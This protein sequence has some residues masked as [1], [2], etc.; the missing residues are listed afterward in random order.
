MKVLT[1]RMRGRRCCLR[2]AKISS[3]FSFVSLFS[4]HDWH[5]AS[6]RIEYEEHRLMA[7]ALAH[8]EAGTIEQ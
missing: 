1:N 6:D 4:C 7:R 3:Y 5:V 2:Q 8:F